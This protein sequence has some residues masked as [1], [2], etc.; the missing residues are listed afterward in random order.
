[1]L[2]LQISDFGMASAMSENNTQLFKSKYPDSQYYMAP[3][4]F[5]PEVLFIAIISIMFAMAMPNTSA[6][7]QKHGKAVDF[8]SLG[9]LAY[10]LVTGETAFRPYDNHGNSAR[11]ETVFLWARGTYKV[12]ALSAQLDDLLRKLFHPVPSERVSGFI[13]HGQELGES[14]SGL[15]FVL[16]HEWFN[17][18][19]EYTD[20]V[21]PPEFLGSER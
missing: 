20:P 5:S 13:P 14:K 19:R 2:A 11:L 21:S 17:L 6:E 12:D 3:E 7:S 16:E 9:S 10:Y 4:I 18:C 15:E 8:W 1:M